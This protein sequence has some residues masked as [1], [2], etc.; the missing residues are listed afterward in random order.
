MMKQVVSDLPDD[1]YRERR[2]F[3]RVDFNVPISNGQIR[4]DYRLRRTVP[5]IEYLSQR[6]AKVVLASHLGK[7]KGSVVPALSLKPVADRLREILKV[8]A[9]KFVGAVVGESVQQAVNAMKS[10][11]VLLLENLRFESGEEANDPVFATQLASLAEIYVNDAF[12]TIH[13][14]H[15]STYGAAQLFSNRLAGFL[16]SKEMEVL[17]QVRDHPAGPFRVVVG[18]I[19]IK[20][21]LSALNALLPKADTVLL[22]GGIAYT[23]LA[24]EGV[25]TGDSPV[26]Q[27]F[28]PWAK[29]MLAQ[30]RGK[31]L[32]P[33][34]HVIARSVEERDGLQNV[35]R[36]IPAGFKGLDIGRDASLTFAHEL[37]RGTGTVFWN[38]PLGTFE[39]D[40]FADGTVD[41]ARAMALAHWRGAFT[42]IGGGDTVAALR[43]AEVLETEVSHVSTG[44]GA[45][46]KF[47][48]G[49]ALPGITVL[50]ET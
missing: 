42:V 15:A 28:M 34:D 50:S 21:K 1:R 48:G 16:V 14:A 13:R 7:P 10:G 2:V 36:A 5:T 41:I 9:V 17:S 39:V 40:E 4:E 3:V 19:K 18:G 12:G 20:D 30:Y 45:S 22:G 44:G 27:E 8:P 33:E 6:G 43:K 25:A 37:L 26:E 32:L 11:E 47:I 35:H 46:L 23:F 31:I 38:G 49:E 29:E 24:A